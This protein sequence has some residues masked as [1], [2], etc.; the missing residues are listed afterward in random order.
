M[1]FILNKTTVTDNNFTKLCINLP[2]G[3]QYSWPLLGLDTQN[4]MFCYIE[5]AVDIHWYEKLQNLINIMN[6]I[7]KKENKLLAI[8]SPWT[9]DDM[10]P[11]VSFIRQALKQ[12]GGINS[13]FFCVMLNF[14]DGPFEH[15]IHYFVYI[16]L[17]CYH[18]KW[19]FVCSKY[20]VDI[21]IT[22]Y[23]WYFDLFL[24]L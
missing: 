15:F 12:G 1:H 7:L 23:S 11:V 9:P 21:H 18:R 4:T 10:Q 22:L 17:Y 3:F 8:H 20:M 14:I 6:L 2:N 13:C 5:M 16:S 24:I 19:S